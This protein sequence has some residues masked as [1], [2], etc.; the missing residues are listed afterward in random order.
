MKTDFAI[1]EVP[2]KVAAWVR[3]ERPPRLSQNEFLLAIM[4]EA[5]NKG[6]TLDLFPEEHQPEVIY[7]GTPFKFI[8]LFAGIGGFRIGMTAAGGRCVFSS[9]WDSFAC[10]T[11][12]NWF[13]DSN[14]HTEDIRLLDPGTIPDHDVLCA[15]FPCQPFSLAGVSKKR[16]MGRADG[17]EDEKQGNL[18]FS[19]LGI[20]DEK[21]PPVLLLENVKNLKSHDKGNTW[22]VIEGSLIDRDYVVF[23]KVIDA[24]GWVPQHRERVFIV[25]FDRRV[26]G[27]ERN[28]GFNFPTSDASYSLGDIL[29]EAPDK[30]YM[31]SDKLWTYLQNYAQKHREKGNGFG[32]GLFGSSDQARTLSARYHKDGSEILIRQKGF[33]N[34]R[35]LTPQEAAKLMG[36]DEQYSRHWGFENGFPQV[37]S[38]TQAYKQFGNSVVPKVVH[39]IAN[40]LA[41]VMSD[42]ILESSKGCLIK[43]RKLEA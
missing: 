43:G 18:F 21:R 24:A 2:E 9:E 19:I 29:G 13:R 8:D 27:G 34:P 17:F 4:E 3:S 23:S 30:K 12:S 22:R 41:Q 26:F 20:V 6:R 33:R 15:G 10:K 32:F 28:I 11:Y 35:R 40:E 7:T 5:Y 39:A 42:H 1:R 25:C 38:D 16:S 36:F 14:V 31:L 37:V